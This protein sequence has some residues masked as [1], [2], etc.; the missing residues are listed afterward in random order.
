ML[1]LY[2][3]D[4]SIDTMGKL[5]LVIAV[6]AALAI[7][8]GAYYYFFYGD[9]TLSAEL[10]ESNDNLVIKG[11]K[12][13]VKLDKNK[14]KEIYLDTLYGAQDGELI[15]GIDNSKVRSGTFKYG[16]SGMQCFA[17]YHKD[18]SYR[19]TISYER[20]NEIMAGDVTGRLVFNLDSNEKTEEFA[21]AL[22][23]F[24]PSAVYQKDGY[25]IP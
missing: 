6:V 18:V 12:L 13:D 5:L 19:I 22:K 24:I 16:V 9:D 10:D 15:S 23:S 14:I 7:A 20:D 11:P 21:L 8:G 4:A 2:S 25:V 3:F 17:N 1:S